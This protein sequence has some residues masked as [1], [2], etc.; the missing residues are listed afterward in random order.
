MEDQP[1]FFRRKD[2]KEHTIPGLKRGYL[3]HTCGVY[4]QPLSTFGNLYSNG[5]SLQSRDKKIDFDRVSPYDKK[6]EAEILKKIV[7]TRISTQNFF[8]ECFVNIHVRIKSLLNFFGLTFYTC[9]IFI[10][11]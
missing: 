3:I 9:A 1:D 8:C 7:K 11:T 4:P 5:S 10:G 2:K 6:D